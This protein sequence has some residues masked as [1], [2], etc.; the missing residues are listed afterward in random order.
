MQS[1]YTGMFLDESWDDPVLFQRYSRK[2][3]LTFD[4]RYC[5]STLFCI[6]FDIFSVVSEINDLW[7]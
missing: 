2:V 1:L 7:S 3:H 4:L 6:D 5:R